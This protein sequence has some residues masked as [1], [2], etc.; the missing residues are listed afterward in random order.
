MA[1]ETNLLQQGVAAFQSGD[2]DRAHELLS[3]YVLIVPEDEQGWYFLAAS[4]SDPTRRK[5]YLE[6][7]LGLNPNNRKAREVLDRIL[8]RETPGTLADAASR[9]ADPIDELLM[10]ES[11]KKKAPSRAKPRKTTSKTTAADAGAAASTEESEA[12]DP[13]PRPKTTRTPK[14]TTPPPTEP[15][16]LSPRT[17]GF[18][19]PFRIPGAPQRTTFE[20][21][22]SEA[23]DLL[24]DGW[25]IML[26]RPDIHDRLID[27]ATW[28]R[29]WLMTVS[30]S[31]GAAFVAVLLSLFIQFSVA[32]SAFGIFGVLVS[33]VVSVPI[34]TLATFAGSYVSYRFVVLGSGGGSTLLKHSMMIALVWQPALIITSVVGFFLVLLGSRGDLTTLMIML[35]AFYLIGEA[36][37]RL[38]VFRDK[39]Q[40]WFLAA[41]F[42]ITTIVVIWLLGGIFGGLLAPGA[43]P[44]GVYW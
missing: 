43:L 35:Y 34:L 18:G 22:S 4:E 6:R 5:L 26:R 19:I 44:F 29:F 14:T 32:P 8:A 7:V 20:E 24:R 30:G 1:D 17:D 28:W 31:L 40:R 13:N 25:Q 9:P 21:L 16:L 41:A 39:N 15:P 42:G 33:P 2:R 10:E 12:T 38:H 3:E 11:T 23:V 37:L 36:S 27:R